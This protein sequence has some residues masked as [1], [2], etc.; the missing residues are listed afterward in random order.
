[1]GVMSS[2]PIFLF[3][4]CHLEGKERIGQLR[5]RNEYRV[6]KEQYS[7]RLSCVSD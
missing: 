5:K 4:L 2:V 7:V 3:F 6:I 1:M